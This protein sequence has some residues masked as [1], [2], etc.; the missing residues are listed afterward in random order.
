MWWNHFTKDISRQSICAICPLLIEALFLWE[1]GILYRDNFCC[2]F[3]EEKL[4]CTYIL[5]YFRT[6]E[7]F[8]TGLLN[9]AEEFKKNVGALADEFESNGPF[10]DATGIPEAISYISSMRTQLADLKNEEDS[11]RRG[12][13]IFKIEQ[14]Q[15]HPL[16]T[17]DKVC[18]QNEQGTLYLM[19]IINM[20]E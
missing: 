11:L 2:L 20:H 7:K 10:S 1:S 9:S 8:R 6:Q 18:R 12:L 15:S 13:S 3:L 17:I 19:A 14:P 4:H 5:H 16:Q